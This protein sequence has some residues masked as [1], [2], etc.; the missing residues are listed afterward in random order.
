LAFIQSSAFV[1]AEARLALFCNE[2]P[3]VA[4][5]IAIACNL[6]NVPGIFADTDPSGR[7]LHNDVRDGLVFMEL[8]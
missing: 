5:A 2:L 3:G 8:Q 7:S 4:H 6:P 1:M